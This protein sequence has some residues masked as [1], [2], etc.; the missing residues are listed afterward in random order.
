MFFIPRA[1]KVY[2]SLVILPIYTWYVATGAL[3]ALLVGAWWSWGYS[4]MIT[5]ISALNIERQSLLIQKKK[6]HELVSHVQN[7][8]KLEEQKRAHVAEYQSKCIGGQSALQNLLMM[9]VAA[10]LELYDSQWHEPVT[11]GS[12]TSYKVRLVVVGSFFQ[13][14]TF[15]KKVRSCTCP[16]RV[17]ELRITRRKNGVVEGMFTMVAQEVSQ[18]EV[19]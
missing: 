17:D 4:S 11:E 15:L 19:V 9:C 7:L 8:R 10:G 5:R 18:H 6:M 2:A 12:Y 1:N 3:I 14:V 13:V 16:V